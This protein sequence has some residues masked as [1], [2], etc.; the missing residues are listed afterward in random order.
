MNWLKATANLALGTGVLFTVCLALALAAL[1]FRL[2]SQVSQEIPQVLPG[3]ILALALAAG[4]LLFLGWRLREGR[5][6]RLSAYQMTMSAV[7]VSAL[8]LVRQTARLLGADWTASGSALLGMS[9][10]L[11]YSGG[12]LAGR[13]ARGALVEPEG[14]TETAKDLRAEVE[15]LVGEIHEEYRRR[16]APPPPLTTWQ[17]VREG[18]LRPIRAF[19]ELKIRPHLELCGIIP[20]VVLLWPRL[21][22][23]ARPGETLGVR[24]LGG[25]DYA[26]WIV[27]YDLGK[28]AMFWGIAQ[29]R[30]R[31]LAYASALAAF[32]IVD[33]PSLTTYVIWNLW[34]GQ[35]VLAGGILHS[36][37]G[38]GSLFTGLATTN[39]PL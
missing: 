6:L 17:V 8:V 35:Y 38:L 37:L 20:L 21:T 4:S 5:R 13:P 31:P 18:F 33:L 34:P 39:P 27:L 22:I 9:G 11:L 32:M 28:A 24:I 15:A 12:T 2:Y 36:R 23:F 26:L 3:L 30:R 10:L 29:A 14:T 25:V 19:R 16:P 7:M 1:V